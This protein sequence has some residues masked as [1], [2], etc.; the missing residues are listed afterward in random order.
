MFLEFFCCVWLFLCD[1]ALPVCHDECSEWKGYDETEHAEEGTPYG[2]REKED[3]RVE[4]HL[5]THDLW[6]DDHIDDDLNDGKDYEGESEDYPEILTCVEGFEACEECRW[7]EGEG[8]EV[9]HKVEDADEDSE[10]DSHRE[11]DDGETD[12]EEDAHG[13][14]YEALTAYVGIEGVGCIQCKLMPEMVHGLREYA[15]PVG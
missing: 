13:E 14:C 8:V 7:D 5:L 4:S 1:V 6:C 10:T 12:A 3:G 9:W 11:V 15:Y 2:E